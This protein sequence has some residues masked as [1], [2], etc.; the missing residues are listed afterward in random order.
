MN[1]LGALVSIATRDAMPRRPVLSA[2]LRK[3]FSPQVN[4]I[5]GMKTGGTRK[6]VI[7]P[8][9]GYQYTART[10]ASGTIIIIPSNS[11]LIFDVEAV[12]SSP[13]P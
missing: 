5:A 7:G 11:V 4:G 3:R 1:G 12:R 6:L 2:P 8:E 13:K 9:S 10:D